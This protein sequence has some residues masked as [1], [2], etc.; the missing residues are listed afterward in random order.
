MNTKDSKLV[1]NP[2]T[3]LRYL[4]LSRALSPLLL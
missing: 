3:N 2:I 4:I 1:I